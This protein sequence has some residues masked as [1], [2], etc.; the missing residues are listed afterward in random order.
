M[1]NKRNNAFFEVIPTSVM[2]L[3]EKSVALCGKEVL[4]G[5]KVASNQI[6]GRQSSI[7]LSGISMTPGQEILFSSIPLS[8]SPLSILEPGRAFLVDAAP[9]KGS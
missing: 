7:G 8:I 4:L 6:L 5:R 1:G 9:F 3:H 2:T